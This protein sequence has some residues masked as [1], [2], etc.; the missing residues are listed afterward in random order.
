MN[1]C[2]ENI[3]NIL[4]K[5]LTVKEEQQIVGGSIN[6]ETGTLDLPKPA[7]QDISAGKRKK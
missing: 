5:K 1:Q 3:K 6:P 7:C 2:E 4:F